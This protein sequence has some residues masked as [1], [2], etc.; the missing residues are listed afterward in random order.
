MTLK[1]AE[2]WS[3]A[4]CDAYRWRAHCYGPVMPTGQHAKMMK[5]LGRMY[6]AEKRE[7]AFRAQNAH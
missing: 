1:T 7:K 2:R 4:W 6:A 5:A 3:D